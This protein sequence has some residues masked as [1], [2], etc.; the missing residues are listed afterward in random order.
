MI[1]FLTIAS[2][3]LG[4]SSALAISSIAGGPAQRV[5]QV[6][7]HPPPLEQQLDHVGRN[8]DRLGRVDQRPLDRLLDPVAGIGAE[9]GSDRG[10][11]ALDGPQQP[12]VPL[13]DQVL[14][15]QPLA[16]VASGDID[17]QPQVGADHPIAGLVVPVGDPVGQL[18]LF[19]GGQQSHLVDL[20][21]IGLQG[22][23]DHV[24]AVSANT[25]HEDPRCV[26]RNRVRSRQRVRGKEATQAAGRL[27]GSEGSRSR[28]SDSSRAMPR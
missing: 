14:E 4:S 23:L 5:L 16:D 15:R 11:K 28:E 3:F 7:G 2:F 9:P 10:V 12:E 8:P 17:H 21:E 13:L 22:A 1:A 26:G 6:G 24:T 18:F 27:A 25:G 19:V 20:P